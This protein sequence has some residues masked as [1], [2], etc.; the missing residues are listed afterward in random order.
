MRT[1]VACREIRPK[2]ELA[3]LVRSSDRRV[4]VD[5]S[6]AAQGRGA[7]VCRSA[8][9]LERGLTRRQLGRAFREPCEAGADLAEEVRTLW[10]QR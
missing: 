3:R 1:C 4:V 7:Y 8:A 10:R 5:R 6:G 2:G 9:C